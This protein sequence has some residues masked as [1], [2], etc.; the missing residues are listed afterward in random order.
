MNLLLMAVAGGLG[1]VA[2]FVIDSAVRSRVRT[3]LP[4]GTLLVNLLGSLVLGMLSGAVLRHGADPDLRLVLGTG[5]CGGLT[6]FS[7][8]SVE[9]VRL[10]QQRRAGLALGY[11]LVGALGCLA[12]AGLGFVLVA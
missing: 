3:A 4:V 10:V 2:R 11:L 5:F 1:A 9:C 8:A 12:A 7:T 6:T